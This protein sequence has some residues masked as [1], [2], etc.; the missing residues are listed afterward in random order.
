MRRSSEMNIQGAKSDMVLDLCRQLKADGYLAGI[1][2]SK[3]YLDAAAFAQQGIQILWQDF[4][5][6]RYAQIPARETFVEKLSVLDLLFN[7][8]P[9][10]G[11]ILRGEVPPQEEKTMM[12]VLVYA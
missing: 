7:C 2:G 3:G 4:R 11:P 5:H 9:Q 8:G 10:S 6:P 12:E 1:G